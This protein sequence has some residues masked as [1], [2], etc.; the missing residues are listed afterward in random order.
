[1]R[2]RGIDCLRRERRHDRDLGIDDA[3]VTR[4]EAAERTEEQVAD[5]EESSHARQLL[6]S[7]PSNQRQVIELAYFKGLSQKSPKR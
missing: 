4:L 1:V 2:N 7:L 5:C 6:L 3:L